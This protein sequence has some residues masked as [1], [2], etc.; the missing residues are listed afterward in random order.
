[1]AK[2]IKLLCTLGPASMDQGIITRLDALG[3]DLFRI[4]LSHINIEALEDI[5]LKVR[6]YTSKPIC[7]DTE[8]AQV[9]TGYVKDG[10]IQLTENSLVEL[11]GEKITGDANRISLTP[12]CI[13]DQI[14]LGDMI[15]LDFDSVLLGVMHKDEHKVTAKVVSGGFIGGNKAV[16]VDRHLQLPI[17]SQKDQEAITIGL[18]HKIRHFA[19][20][21]AGNG[22]SVTEFR[23]RIGQDAFLISKVESKE[24]IQ[25]INEILK[26]SDAVLID[27]GDLSR[28]EPIDKIPFI[29][30]L[31]IKNANRHKVPVYVATN[32]LESMV[33][34]KKPTRAEANDV[35][36]TLLDGADGLVLA[37]ETAIG[38][39]PVNCAVMIKK[40]IN[41]FV[42]YCNGNS[43]E[44]LQRKDSFLLTPP[45]GGTLVNRVNENYNPESIKKYKRLEV[46]FTVLLNAEQIAIGTFSPLEGFMTKAEVES[47][48][49]HHKLPN[50]VIWPLPIVLQIPSK[51]AR[52]FKVGNKVALTLQNTDEVYAVLEI[53]DIY[54]CNL[55]NM[56]KETFGTNDGNHPGVRLFKA[57]G[58]SFLGGKIEL[59]KRLPSQCKNYELTPRQSRI[60]F[61]TKGWS[62]VVGFHTRN[63]VHRA[64]EYIQMAAFEKYHC[65][66]IF[67]HPVIGPKKSED[68]NAEIIL[69]SYEWMINKHYPKGKVI[70]G[71]F[72]NYSRYAGPREA[73][74]TAICRKNF[75]CS[76]FII[77]R[78]HTGVG[79]YYKPDD[80]H[81]L[82]DALGDI[83]IVP[84]FFNSMHYC[85]KCA[86]YVEQCG[87]EAADILK[88]SGTQGREMLKAREAPPDWFMREDISNIILDEIDNGKEVFVK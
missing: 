34:S 31:I 22:K 54:S 56:A 72:Q 81:R 64:H 9:R 23:E 60:I 12:D 45:H 53:D 4:N 85:R 30:K 67:I 13:I 33:K 59:I 7:L 10:L 11:V 82:F 63:V 88:I 43:L 41:N 3:V 52:Q 29:Q 14:R 42:E 15:S 62:R 44:E 66:G 8:G 78:D 65:D 47:V 58:E 70:L 84:I 57:R 19:L 28:E 25:N 68:Y 18:K 5:I 71:A 50:G 40:M 36:N 69:E 35:I 61:E 6:Q 86:H 76:H 83:G 2:Q 26:L 1:M 55:D 87:H 77:G 79:N 51:K 27:R 49:H 39:Y 20:S 46:D 38:N 17:L 75:G 48:L 37:A 16:A 32:L 24:A 21:F 74:F 73:V 80:A